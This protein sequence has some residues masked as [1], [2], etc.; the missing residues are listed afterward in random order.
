MLKSW[1]L[2]DLALENKKLFQNITKDF[3]Q[4]TLEISLMFGDWLDVLHSR[5][6]KKEIRLENAS[7]TGVQIL[8][9]NSAQVISATHRIWMGLDESGLKGKQSSL[10]PVE[11]ITELKKV[12]DLALE[13]PEESHADFN[14]RWFA[15]SKAEEQIFTCS[16]VSMIGDPLTTSLFFLENNKLP[17]CPAENYTVLESKQYNFDPEIKFKD[18]PI[19]IDKYKRE[20]EALPLDIR[21]FEI[22]SL[23]PSDLETYAQCSYKFLARKGYKLRALDLLGV[24]ID[25]QQKGNLVH[26]LFKF[27]IEGKRYLNLDKDQMTSYLND[28]RVRRNL[29]PEM[30]YFWIPYRDKLIKLG[31]QFAEIEQ[32]RLLGFENLKHKIEEPLQIFY[33]L[34]KFEFTA[35]KPSTRYFVIRGRLDRLDYIE[36]NQGMIIDYKSGNSDRTSFADKWINNSEFQL[37][38][39]AL[40]AEKIFSLDIKGAV[41]Y[42]YK[43]FQHNYGYLVNEE[44]SFLEH[45]DYTKRTLVSQESQQ[46]MKEEF[47]DTVKNIFQKIE[48]KVFVVKP[49]NT[50]VCDTC[51]W[52]NTC[53]IKCQ[54]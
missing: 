48:E 9:I 41:Y 6:A 23:S 44:N 49:V 20:M 4:Q 19:L 8:P 15:M 50:K 30:N 42:F 52:S 32:K 37:L 22:K 10:I 28:E 39:Y 16:H 11:D 36:N 24:E 51:E 33:D 25:A 18:H 31:L 43:N 2:T 26:D 12:F 38:I 21:N 54:N 47:L 53:R 14:L 17:K 40:I 7:I 29:F 13:Y 34:E 35:A 46:E 3:I 5:L 1:I 27:I 45:V